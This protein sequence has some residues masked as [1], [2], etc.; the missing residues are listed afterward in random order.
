MEIGPFIVP[1]ILV[2]VGFAGSIYGV[3]MRRRGRDL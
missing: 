3:R 2:V 1:I